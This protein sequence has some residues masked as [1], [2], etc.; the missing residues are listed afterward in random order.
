MKIARYL[1][2]AAL[3]FFFSPA[4][5]SLAAPWGVAANYLDATI[6]TVDLGTTPPT[7]Y[8]PFLAGQ[9]GSGGTWDLAITPDSRYALATSYNG[10]SVYRIDLTDPTAPT[11][12]GALALPVITGAPA[13]GCFTALD[14]AVAPNGQFA[15]IS[16]GRSFIIPPQPPTNRL[17]FIDLATFTYT[18]TYTLTTLNGSAQAV[19]I[20]ADSQTIIMADRAGGAAA[21]PF[22]GR[23]IFGAVNAAKDGLISESTL[24]T[25][26]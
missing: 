21:L 8:G 14:I 17:G 4:S 7:V 2:A 26:A 22:P 9:L 11:L 12:A 1:T 24:S 3:L 6:S 13:P 25:G 10:C 18:G 20:A 23:I 15:V 19:A 5:L 16:S